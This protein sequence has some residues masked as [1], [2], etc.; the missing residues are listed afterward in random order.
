MAHE[1]IDLGEFNAPSKAAPPPHAQPVSVERIRMLNLTASTSHELERAIELAQA[2]G[3]SV[4]D[5]MGG[6]VVENGWRF[7]LMSKPVP[8]TP[9]GG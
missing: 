8:D 2:K 9:K 7:Q 6:T 3:W 1:F 5:L 4:M